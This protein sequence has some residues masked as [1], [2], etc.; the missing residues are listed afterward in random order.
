MNWWNSVSW[1]TEYAMASS[2][3]SGAC[4]GSPMMLEPSTRM[5]CDCSSPTSVR[6][7]AFASFT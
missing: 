2:M 4:S 7:S 1:D 6:V 5:P 3:V